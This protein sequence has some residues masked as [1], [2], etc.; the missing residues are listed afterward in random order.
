[1]LP[2][3]YGLSNKPS[4]APLSSLL[5]ISTALG[6]A[7]GDIINHASKEIPKPEK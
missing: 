7:W 4:L 2:E 1:L 3:D 5:R 6:I